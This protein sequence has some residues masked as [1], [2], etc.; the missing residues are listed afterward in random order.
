MKTYIN[1]P[2]KNFYLCL[3]ENWLDT[4][5]EKEKGYPD[6]MK[7]VV[8]TA[9]ELNTGFFEDSDAI[10]FDTSLMLPQ[11]YIERKKQRI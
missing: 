2:Y 7:I 6:K 5:Y 1:K 11:L 3:N 4:E 9:Q 8:H 10:E